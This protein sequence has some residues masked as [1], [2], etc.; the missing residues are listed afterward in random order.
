MSQFGDTM[1]LQDASRDATLKR[2]MVQCIDG[3][4]LNIARLVHCL[5]K[6]RS[7]TALG[8]ACKSIAA[9]RARTAESRTR[10]D[11]EL[12]IGRDRAALYFL[13]AVSRLMPY[14][15]EKGSV[16]F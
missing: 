15:S 12:A 7:Y 6:E 13:N 14:A 9:R 2:E 1:L 11:A 4:H 3:R 16:D 8:A 5:R 10:R